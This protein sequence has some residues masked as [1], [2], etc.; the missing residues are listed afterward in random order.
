M[1]LIADSEYQ[2][3]VSIFFW[4]MDPTH[5]PNIKTDIMCYVTA[6][7]PDITKIEMKPTFYFFLFNNTK[8]A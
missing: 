6:C 3:V 4:F 2:S 1:L 8:N 5:R 7:D